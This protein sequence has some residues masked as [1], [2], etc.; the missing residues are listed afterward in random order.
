MF[1][2]RQRIQS[3]GGRFAVFSQPGAGAEIRMSVPIE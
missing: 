2:M 3:M 1:N